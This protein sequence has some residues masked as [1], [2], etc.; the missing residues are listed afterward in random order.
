MKKTQSAC[1]MLPFPLPFNVIIFFPSK[2]FFYL[3]IAN[4]PRFNQL[5]IIESDAEINI[6]FL[7]V[8]KK[9]KKEKEK[10]K[11]LLIQKTFSIHHIYSY[12]YRARTH[13]HT[14]IRTRAC[15]QRLKIT[16]PVKRF[17]C[18]GQFEF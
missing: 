18:S 10:K 9:G 8:S 11:V 5:M 16:F 3:T 6:F 4:R 15:I 1:V 7:K 13:A 12:S 2:K 17:V 14:H